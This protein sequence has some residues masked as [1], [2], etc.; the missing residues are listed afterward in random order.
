MKNVKYNN[1]SQD[2]STA[3]RTVTW[4]VNDGGAVN[5]LSNTVTTSITVTAVND[6]PTATSYTGASKLDAQAGIMVTYPAGTLGGT[7]VEAGTT[8]TINTTPDG[9]CSGCT[10]VLR[11]D[12]SFDFTPPPG[13]AGTP[14]SF[15]Y[16]VSDNGIPAPGVDSAAA[17]VTFDVAGPA[18]FFVKSSGSGTACTL[19]NECTIDTAVTQI[20]VLTNAVIFMDDNS[21]NTA[22]GAVTLN[23]GGLVVGQGVT[24]TTF[25]TLFSI[26]TPV[27]GT[28][29]TLPALGQPRPTISGNIVFH[30][31]S[32]ARGFNQSTSTGSAMSASGKSGLTVSEVGITG[33]GAASGVNLATQAGTVSFSNIDVTT[34]TGTAFSIG[35]TS[36]PT[37][38]VT[39]GSTIN[40]VSGQGLI[41]SALNV[42]NSGIT[43]DNLKSG[44]GANNVSLS[45]V[46]LPGG[47]TGTVTLG[48]SGDTLTNA[49]VASF[50]LSSSS[51]TVTYA[52]SITS[53]S[54]HSVQI[55]SHSGTKT[56]TLSGLVTDNDTG[57]LLTNNGASGGATIN[58]SGGVTASTGT[59]PAFTATGGGTVNVTGAANTLATTTGTALDVANTTI[60]ASGLHFESIASN[61]AANGI[62]L[63]TTGIAGGLVVH[64]TGSAG[65]GGTI[66]N[67][68]ASGINANDTAG[69]SLSWMNLTNNG[70]AANEDNLTATYVSG[71]VLISHVVFTPSNGTD[72]NALFDVPTPVVVGSR[73][74]NLT[75]DNSTF[76]HPPGA[77]G[78]AEDSLLVQGRS[79]WAMN[80]TI[81][82]STFLGAKGD[83]FQLNVLENSSSTLNVTGNTFDN[84]AYLANTASFGGGIT[85]GGGG[86]TATPHMTY[87]IDNNIVKFAKNIQLAVII[88]GGAAD[89]T[90]TIS[91][92]QFGVAG[93][94]GSGTFQGIG[95]VL[96]GNGASTAYILNNQVHH[97]Q[98]AGMYFT[99]NRGS[100]S[101]TG[102]AAKFEIFG[103]TIATPDPPSIGGVGSGGLQADIGLDAPDTT[104][105]CFDI[106]S[107][108][109]PGNK[110]TLNG[111]NTQ[112]GVINGAGDVTLIQDAS[113]VGHI[114][115]PSY[116]VNDNGAA[117]TA[118]IQG[119]NNNGGST[120]VTAAAASGTGFRTVA[121][122]ACH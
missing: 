5:N 119:R 15:T 104:T 60:G 6:P 99:V 108:T 38:T 10:V 109:V 12:G 23:S 20:G 7:D 58:F 78:V 63:N 31:N 32:V 96:N 83:Q 98:D 91:N 73:T 72:H 27:G 66:Q 2:P 44:G 37:L 17:T 68:T 13:S 97:Y 29:A 52:G 61:G 9:V 24:G 33:T 84:S 103:N 85:I 48:T 112:N 115:L 76:N 42:G 116:G 21:T 49:S 11:A 118:Y 62:I 35:G 4:Q 57:I 90:G 94:V 3:T 36:S 51:V 65:S 56:V 30:N 120:T 100:P 55:A 59:N 22:A 47:G 82:N 122:G 45:T 19:G 75:I 34:A 14:V 50:N 71:T 64:G 39:G 93:T 95:F 26:P 77:S 121:A 54:G 87:T 70:N 79:S 113:T 81:S 53:G 89:Y 114:D 106:G 88:N 28:L 117:A 1:T 46:G 25:A 80:T 41:L 105:A 69:L 101:Y 110:N 107:T 92:N 86:G 16:H 18:I 74:L 67:S 111:S 8:I 40:A 43:F 102:M